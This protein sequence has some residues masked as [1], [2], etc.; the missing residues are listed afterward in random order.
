MLK[1]EII[2]NGLKVSYLISDN[3]QVDQAIIFLPG[4]NS[5]ADIFSNSVKINNLLAI[6]LPGFFGSEKPQ[7]VWGTSDYADF[8]SEFLNKLNIKNSI[9]VGHSFGGAV[10]LRYA[11]QNS[12]KKLILIGA[13]IV[14]TKTSKT[15]IYYLGAKILKTLL[16]WLAKKLRQSFY[17]R[18]GSLDYLESG[19]MS[20]IYQKIIREDSQV[21]LK[22]IKNTPVTLIWGEK[23]LATPLTQ[24]YLIKNQLPN[25]QL[26][27]LSGAGHYCFLDNK[28]EFDKIFFKEI[29]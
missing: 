22:E 26:Y 21:Y 12:V 17:N 15:R 27:V 28:P 5:P 6:N 13:A 3:F 23:D 8:L 1:K 9:V 10:A 16:P 25:S 11:S 4:W 2:I 24:A 19:Q 29:L 18:I 7:T 14:R 20:D